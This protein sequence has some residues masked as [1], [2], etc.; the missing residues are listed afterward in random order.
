[1]TIA[2]IFGAALLT[3]G[4]VIRDEFKAYPNVDRWLKEVGKLPSWKAVERGG[5]RVPRLRQGSAVRQRLTVETAFV[6][7]MR[8]LRAPHS[9]SP[10][11]C[12]QSTSLRLVA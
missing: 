11:A 1:M 4:H 12:D 8:R 2:D 7:S 10:V 9:S 3:S 5:R 6:I